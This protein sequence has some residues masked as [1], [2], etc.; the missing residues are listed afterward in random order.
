MPIARDIFQPLRE[1]QAQLPAGVHFAR[2]DISDRLPGG[3]AQVPAVHD[4][5]YVVRPWHRDA[6]TALRD[7]NG[8]RVR[9]ENLG[10]QFVGATGKSQGSSIVTFGLPVGVE[11]DD[12]DDDV[13]LFRQTDGALHELIGV[14]NLRTAKPYTRIGVHDHFVRI[15]IG[16]CAD[17]AI[18]NKDRVGNTGLEL[19]CAFLLFRAGAEEGFAATLLSP[20][21][22]DEIV[23]YE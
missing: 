13:C 4:G 23:V 22:D 14:L 12:R 21:I 19:V 18:F 5:R 7:H 17:V 8:L 6:R 20:V 9:L 11:A 2:Q 10:H 15:G 3:V 16:R 1:S